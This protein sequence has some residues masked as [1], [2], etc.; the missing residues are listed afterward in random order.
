[1]LFCLDWLTPLETDYRQVL[2]V[3]CSGR[4]PGNCSSQGL[5]I[6]VTSGSKE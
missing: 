1:M 3:N 4:G 2:S 5:G 6:L